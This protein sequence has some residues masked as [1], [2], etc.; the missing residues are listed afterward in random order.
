MAFSCRTQSGVLVDFGT[1]PKNFT[2]GMDKKRIR[3]LPF[4]KFQTDFVTQGCLSFIVPGDQRKYLFKLST[5]K[6]ESIGDFKMFVRLK[7]EESS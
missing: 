4:F 1:F 2:K 3:S 6:I 7:I 5:T